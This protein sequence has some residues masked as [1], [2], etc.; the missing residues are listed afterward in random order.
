MK[1]LLHIIATP[2]GELSRTLQVSNAFLEEVLQQNSYEIEKLNL[3][4]SNLPAFSGQKAVGK[5]ELMQGEELS[6]K[7]AESWQEILRL[8]EHFLSFDAYLFSVPMWNFSV[9]YVLKQYIDL[10]FQP[11]Y[12]FKYTETGPRGM[13]EGKKAL[14]ITSRGGDY[15]SGTAKLFDNQEPYFKTAFPFIGL[16][17]LTFI[18]AEPMDSGGKELQLM[19]IKE[20]QEKARKTAKTF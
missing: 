7:S 9:P 11:N 8:I 19:R 4:E 20:A 12:L 6:K 16:T 3:F 2:R 14:I 10:I 1:K 5:Y 17:D 13:A 15:S 18:H